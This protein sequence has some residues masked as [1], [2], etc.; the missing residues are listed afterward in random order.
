[1][2]LPSMPDSSLITLRAATDA[3]WDFLR[4]V[5]AGTRS[6]ELAAL[7]WDL[8]MGQAFIEMQFRVQA[9]N[10]KATYPSA[11]N[12]II[13]SDGAPVGRMLV[14]RTEQ[15]IKLVDIAILR[16]HCGAGIGSKLIQSLLDEAARD[17]KEVQ[18]SV[19]KTNPAA[20][21]YQRLGFST[22]A[23]DGVYFEMSW[24]NK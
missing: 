24:R 7:A 3:D 2:L 18:L 5:F 10:Y 13:L 22:V 9:Q 15:A 6:D 1:M 8:K 20:R 21:L 16:D 17:G 4:A 19:F 12:N 23:D 14:D 11:Q